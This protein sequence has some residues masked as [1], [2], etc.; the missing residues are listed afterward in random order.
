MAHQLGKEAGHEEISA[1]PVAITT[2]LN[3]R[4]SAY[5]VRRG[6][7]RH[8]LPPGRRD[9]GG[10]GLAPRLVAVSSS[11]DCSQQPGSPA[12]RGG[13]ARAGARYLLAVAPVLPLNAVVECI[14]A[15]AC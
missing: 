6:G 11:S 9:D 13:A 15:V 8:G 2:S 7:P 12:L 3:N 1:I 10:F 5:P 4:D 14:P